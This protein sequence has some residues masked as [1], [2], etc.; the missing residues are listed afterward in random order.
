HAPIAEVPERLSHRLV[1]EASD[2]RDILES[3]LAVGGR[4]TRSIATASARLIEGEDESPRVNATVRAMLD[5]GDTLRDQMELLHA[6]LENSRQQISELQQ[7]LFESQTR[8][9]VDPLT[10]AGNRAYFDAMMTSLMQLRDA[11]ND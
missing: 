9:M 3:Q 1:V 5:S 8:L 11:H 2:L 10:G 6:R 4:F 7:R